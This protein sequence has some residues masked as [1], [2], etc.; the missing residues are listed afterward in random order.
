MKLRLLLLLFSL[1][2]IG[3]FGNAQDKEKAKNKSKV[4]NAQPEIPVTVTGSKKSTHQKPPPLPKIEKE[5]K[6]L[7]PVEVTKFT[8]PKIVKDSKAPPPPPAPGGK[9]AI[10]KALPPTKVEM[11]P[12]VTA[13]EMK[14][15]KILPPPPPPPPAPGKKGAIIRLLPPTKVGMPP[16]LTAKEGKVG[17]ILPP[18]PPR[19]KTAHPVPEL[20]MH[21]QLVTK[22]M[23][24]SMARFA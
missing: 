5:G 23:K 14:V 20:Y 10:I 4:E 21:Y 12:S 13:K 8:P 6:P 16:S 17:K 7:P 24:L 3:L 18:P 1:L 19:S 22:E 11:P 15:E 9:G 2:G